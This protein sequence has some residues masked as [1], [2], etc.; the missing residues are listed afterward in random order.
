MNK[1]QVVKAT[2]DLSGVPEQ[3]YG[4][5]VDD[6][7]VLLENGRLYN[8]NSSILQVSAMQNVLPEVRE[9]LEDALLKVE[10]LD[11][12]EEQIE[13]LNK[14]LR[15]VNQE[16]ETVFPAKLRCARG[17][18]SQTEFVTE[19][20]KNL[21]PDIRKALDSYKVSAQ[22]YKK[23]MMILIN[24]FAE[25]ENWEQ[26]AHD[27][28]Y[29]EGDNE[30]YLQAGAEQT[31]LYQDIVKKYSHLLPVK[32]GMVREGLCFNIYPNLMY[33]CTYSVFV[34]KSLTKAYA[35]ELADKFCGVEREILDN[36]ETSFFSK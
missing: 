18:L 29:E 10:A 6:N 28:C 24:Y 7:R 4:I 31:K 36:K 35:K 13:S 23:N 15:E 34:T 16:L 5:I 8:L 20:T 26:I 11:K 2:L 27:I 25:V 33:F 32:E 21:T 1:K 22:P 14:R 17:L 9:V 12:T 19:F 30:W 3:M